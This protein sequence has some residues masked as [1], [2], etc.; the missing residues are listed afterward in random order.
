MSLLATVGASGAL[1]HDD[2]LAS[3]RDRYCERRALSWRAFHAESR[4]DQ[5][6]Q[7]LD[8]IKPQADPFVFPSIRAIELTKQFKDLGQGLLKNADTSIRDGK[9]YGF[10]FDEETGRERHRAAIGKFNSIVDQILQDRCQLDTIRVDC[11]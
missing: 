8:K 4:A 1:S 6:R 7:F 5:I 10:P 11:R 3:G 2:V 9:L